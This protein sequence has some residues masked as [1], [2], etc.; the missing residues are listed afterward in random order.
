ML[1]YYAYLAVLEDLLHCFDICTRAIFRLVA[2]T[3]ICR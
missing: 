1:D 2:Y 3:S